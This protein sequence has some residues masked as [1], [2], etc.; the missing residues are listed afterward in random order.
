MLYVKMKKYKHNNKIFYQDLD[1]CDIVLRIENYYW[2]QSDLTY[3]CNINMRKY[4]L[5]FKSNG[6]ECLEASSIT[7]NTLGFY[8][9]MK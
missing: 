3:S 2:L 9:N 4:Y 6:Q 7:E 5:C 8:I 1:Y